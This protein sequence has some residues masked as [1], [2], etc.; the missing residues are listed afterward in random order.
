MTTVQSVSPNTGVW[1]RLDRRAF[2]NEKANEV[3]EI[4]ARGYAKD[5]KK[6]ICKGAG[7]GSKVVTYLSQRPL[8]IV[9]L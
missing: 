2:V 4:P 7:K 9:E 6:S 3:V 5:M 8:G 1:E